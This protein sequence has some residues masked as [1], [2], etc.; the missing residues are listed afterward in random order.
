LGFASRTVYSA[1]GETLYPYMGAWADGCQVTAVTGTVLIVEWQ[2]GTDKWRETLLAPGETR[3]IDLVGS[4]DS[5]LIESPDNGSAF[6][7]RLNNCESK[8]RGG[9]TYGGQVPPP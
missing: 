2:R 6:S 8:P 4:E 9:G 3:V 1:Q 7:V 5:A